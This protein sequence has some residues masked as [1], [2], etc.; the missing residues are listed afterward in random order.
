M[1]RNYFVNGNTLVT[2]D[3]SELGIAESSVSI[4]INPKHLEIKVSTFGPDVPPEV[5]AMLADANI[6]MVLVN[7]DIAVLNTCIR[8]SMAAATLGTMQIAGTLMGANSHFVSLRI[9]SP[10]GGVPWTFPSCYLTGS[11]IT[12]PL[13]NERSLVSLN[14]KAIPYVADPASSANAVLFT[15]T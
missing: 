2:A 14:F 3:G 11:P 8:K 15:N 9:A 1:A 12:W 5:Q 10:T 13:G 4:T 7:F 6:G